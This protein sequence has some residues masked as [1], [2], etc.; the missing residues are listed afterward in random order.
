MMKYQSTIL[1][2]D[3]DPI[4]RETLE[5]LL[6]NQGYNLILAT[7]GIEAL[8][9]AVEIIPDVI[10]SDVM[11]PEM[12]GFELCRRLRNNPILAEVPI[13]L[14]TTLDDRDSRLQGIEAGADDFISK[15]FDRTELRTRIRT[16][17][18]LN[19]FRRLLTERNKFEW[20]IDQAEDG[21]LIITDKGDIRYANQKARMYLNLSFDL[22]KPITKTFQELAKEQYRCEPQEAW[23]SHSWLQQMNGSKPVAR[24]LVRPE[25]TTATTFWLQVELLR[26]E[27]HVNYPAEFA[28]CSTSSNGK[29]QDHAYPLIQ[30]VTPK[31]P[32]Y[33]DNISQ[34]WII[35]L[36]D[37]TAQMAMQRST[38]Q[39]QAMVTHK[40]RTPLIG[41]VSGME[42]LANQAAD[43]STAE[44]TALANQA[45]QGVNRLRNTIN[46]IVEY[47]HT[48]GLAPA[49]PNQ[50]FM[51]T[52]LPAIVTEICA[53]L[54]LAEVMVSNEKDLGHS[55]LL[56]R[57]SPQAIKLVL[58]EILENAKKFHPQQS[59]AVTIL[60]SQPNG[61]EIRLQISDDGL[62]LSP[63]QL[64][65]VWTPYYQGEK[66]FTGE[67]AGMGLGLPM[68]ASAMWG[69]GG[70][71]RM[72][73]REKEPGVTVELVIPVEKLDG[74]S[75]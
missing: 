13:I 50:A 4:G 68:V 25:S 47:T 63:E 74:V 69:I 48:P 53:D 16:I 51:L 8:A 31:T 45:L 65:Q 38:W 58:R 75:L 35:R 37:V 39:F 73:N 43:F 40:M 71:C 23:A 15:P 30:S 7:N 55:L 64:A 54:G 33:E 11:M 17:T 2:T 67:A 20:V 70:A 24:Y 10:L 62:T 9:K 27:S 72:Y 32:L 34:E 18:R 3:D 26:I 56:L 41:M 66:F 28:T 44:I 49:S 42:L 12:D 21:Y 22:N 14:I 46:D 60:I 59:P 1:I 19:R 5:T 52:E 6:A 29:L 36:R 57:I 61:R